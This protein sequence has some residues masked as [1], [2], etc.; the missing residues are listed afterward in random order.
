[1]VQHPIYIFG[2]LRGPQDR[3]GFASGGV[4]EYHNSPREVSDGKRFIPPDTQFLDGS[5]GSTAGR[6]AGPHL[7]EPVNNLSAPTVVRMRGFPTKVQL[8][9]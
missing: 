6:F 2:R 9:L 1:V 5:R 7:H 3:P 4:L 8:F